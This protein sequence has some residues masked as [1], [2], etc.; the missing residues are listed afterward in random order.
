MRRSRRT[1][2]ELLRPSSWSWSVL[3]AAVATVRGSGRRA[4]R[5]RCLSLPPSPPRVRTRPT[6]AAHPAT[7]P[8]VLRT[9]R[10]V[11]RPRG[12]AR[13]RSRPLHTSAARA[14]WAEHEGRRDRTLEGASVAAEEAGPN[15]RP[16]T[17]PD[18][19]G[20]RDRRARNSMAGGDRARRSCQTRRRS[21]NTARARSASPRSKLLNK[22]P[23]TERVSS[24]L[25]RAS[26]SSEHG[27]FKLHSYRRECLH[28]S[29]L[30]PATRPPS[31]RASYMRIV[32]SLSARTRPRTDNRRAY[33][34]TIKEHTI[35][36]RRVSHSS[37]C[38]A[39]VAW[40]FACRVNVLCNTPQHM[41][42][43]RWNAREHEPEQEKVTRSCTD[44]VHG[45]RRAFIAIHC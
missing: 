8:A 7:R 44:E 26:V 13:I 2:K 32:H 21:P 10:R 25:S 42:C 9:S 31:K 39:A 19:D 45:R 3:R 5:R 18:D 1:T 37:S 41:P 36:G 20:G 4:S 43:C 22:T 30:D 6:C 38:R 23:R 40:P 33:L 17:W 12:T 34:C 15:S 24:E 35:T 28:R 11:D 29:D 16:P 27:Y 14:C